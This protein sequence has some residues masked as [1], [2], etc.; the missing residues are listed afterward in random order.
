MSAAAAPAAGDAPAKKGSKKMLVIA[1]AAVLLLGG[2]G[3]AFFLM[4]KKAAAEA[5]DGEEVSAD[6]GHAKAA[7][8]AP[9][10]K[11]APKHDPGHP[12]TY[13]ALDPFVVN[14]ADRESE[15]YAQIGMTLEVDD[16]K[17]AEQM[18]GY[19]PAIR[20]SILMILAHKTA[21]ELLSREGK[22]TLAEEIMRE[23]V[24]PMGI[25]ID[26]PEP[27]ADAGKKKRKRAPVYNPVTQVHF[28]SFII[29]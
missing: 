8:H 17:F 28:S 20:N 15:R 12:P 23:A 4:K 14:L 2:G 7:A 5:E 27:E 10:P 22:E 6:A 21:V 29:Q 9:A 1:L 13:V 24:R 3:A 19:M 11:A 18:K 16:P 26:P 25:E